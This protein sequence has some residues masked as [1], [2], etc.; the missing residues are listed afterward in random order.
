MTLITGLEIGLAAV[1]VGNVRNLDANRFGHLLHQ[2]VLME[3]TQI[4]S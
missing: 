2:D 1:E 4:R 3:I